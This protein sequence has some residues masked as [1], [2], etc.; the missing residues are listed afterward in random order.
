MSQ[1]LLYQL[2]ALPAK[3]I[4]NTYTWT[5]LPFYAVAQ[6]P[7]AKLRLTAKRIGVISTI[8]TKTGRRVY[9]RPTFPGIDHPHL[10]FH[11]INDIFPILDR[12]REVLGVR[13]VISEHV[14]LDEKTGKEV[15]IDGKP[16]KKLQL[17]PDFRWI[18]VGEVLDRVESIAKAFKQN[19]GVKPGDHVLIY[20]DNGV[21]WFYSA[22]ALVQINAVM[23][24]LFSTLD[25]N[26]VLFGVNHSDAQFVITSASLLPKIVR[27]SGKFEKVKSIVYID[28]KKQSASKEANQK[29]E[30]NVKQLRERG[31]EVITLEKLAEGGSKLPK[32]NFPP[33]NP[34]ETMLIMYTSL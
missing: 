10:K 27:L 20:A 19:L 5:T 16:L 8:D 1:Q 12:S 18:T 13:D 32:M 6:R 21:E 26:G 22:M 4:V 14:A 33:P 7:W 31:L 9:S 34:D 11:T 23:V 17:A 29:T 3:A 28:D 25:D 15:I 24:T 2:M 30:T